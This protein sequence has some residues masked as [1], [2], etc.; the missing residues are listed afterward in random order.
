MGGGALSPARHQ[1]KNSGCTQQLATNT[2]KSVGQQ[3]GL[4]ARLAL[5]LSMPPLGLWFPRGPL[6]WRGPNPQAYMS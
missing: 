6:M 3:Q 4:G 1:P 5:F 2:A